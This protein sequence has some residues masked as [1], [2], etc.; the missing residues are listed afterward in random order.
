[1]HLTIWL[2]HVSKRIPYLGSLN[3]PS[4]SIVSQQGL[5]FVSTIF[6]KSE[7]FTIVSFDVAT[8][9]SRKLIFGI[10]YMLKENR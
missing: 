9:F 3:H 5:C 2:V 8:L 10:A 7:K 6:I 1:M 4:I